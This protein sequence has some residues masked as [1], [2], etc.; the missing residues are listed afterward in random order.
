MTDIYL[1]SNEIIVEEKSV[2][3]MK[4]Y[5]K[6]R[7]PSQTIFIRN[8]KEAQKL[9]KRVAESSEEMRFERYK[10]AVQDNDLLYLYNYYNSCS[11]FD[12]LKMLFGKIQKRLS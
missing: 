4:E 10:E 11:T 8:K 9:S 7:E 1:E 3:Q 12:L 2:T 5:V 6:M